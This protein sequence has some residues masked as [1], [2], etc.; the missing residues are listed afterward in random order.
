[1]RTDCAAGAFYRHLKSLLGPSQAIVA[2][3]HMLA[4]IVYRM[5]KYKVEYQTMRAEEYEQRFREREI[6]YLQHKA[7]RLCFT[8]SPLATD[9]HTVS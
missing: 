2:T 6:K 9:L 3:V 4:R 1:V 7:A 5:L 8:L